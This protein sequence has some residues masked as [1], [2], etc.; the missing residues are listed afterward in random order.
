MSAMH[1]SCVNNLK[2]MNLLEVNDLKMHFPIHGGVTARVIGAVKAV[3][4]ISLKSIKVR[5]WGS[6]VSPVA[7][8]PR[9]GRPSS[10]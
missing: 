4:G 9:L 3:D 8:S 10:G 5:L 6:S 7:V 2:Y 1:R